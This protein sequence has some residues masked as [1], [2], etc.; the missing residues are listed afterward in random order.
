MKQDKDSAVS[1]VVGVMLMLVVT[2]IIAAVV[3][4]FA[5]GLVG[6]N[7]KTLQ[8]SIKVSPVIES[9]QD[10]NTSNWQPDYPPGFNATNG[11]LFEHAGG[12]SFALSEIAIQIQS[13]D[14][15]YT[16]SMT[17][18][19]PPTTCLP[20]G[21]TKYLAEIGSNDGFI[22]PGDKF[23]LYADNCEI[24]NLGSQISWKPD[25]AEG[26]MAAYLHT[27]CEYAIIDKAS[28]KV[29]QKGE[30]VLQ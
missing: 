5:G 27:R 21:P 8:A 23:M 24:D 15:K 2:I 11:L 22:T 25:G 4:G 7:K 29:I 20:G 9:I 16:I 18:N 19:I 12:D 26:G 17:D 10:T 1:P 28:Q 13:Q 30:F 14:T 6:E 3:S